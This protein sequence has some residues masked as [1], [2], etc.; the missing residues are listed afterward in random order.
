MDDFPCSFSFYL[1]KINM[2]SLLIYDFPS[3]IR[4]VGTYIELEV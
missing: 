2:N 3:Q 1:N 4:R